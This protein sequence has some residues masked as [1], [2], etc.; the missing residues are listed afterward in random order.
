MSQIE[1]MIE[2]E[3]RLVIRCVGSRR[4]R[5]A[6]WELNQDAFAALLARLDPDPERA[7]AAYVRIC[8]RL[9]KFFEC[10]GCAA[11]ADLADET[12]NRVARRL[13]EGAEIRAA[14]PLP[15]FYGVARNVLREDQKSRAHQLLPL[16]DLRPEEHPSENPQQTSDHEQTRWERER[17]LECLTSCLRELPDTARRLLLEYHRGEKRA[18]IEHRQELAA[19][20]GITANALKIR[21]HR[22]RAALERRVNELLTCETNPELSH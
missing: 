3:R 6:E 5:A 20:L 14:E 1:I 21:V 22:L 17:R 11:P 4:A 12:I 9:S 16:A 15:Y 13:A 19:R 18:R 2:T 10:R 8:Q 7:G